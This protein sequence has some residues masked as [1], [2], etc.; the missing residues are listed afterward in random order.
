MHTPYGAKK[1]VKTLFDTYNKM[2][3][4]Q[5]ENDA[6]EKKEISKEKML[7]SVVKKKS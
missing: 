1:Y 2:Q 7:T 6:K 3:Q 5:K 4:M